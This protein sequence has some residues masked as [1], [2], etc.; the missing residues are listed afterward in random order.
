MN[1]IGKKQIIEVI[2][3]NQH[4]PYDEVKRQAEEAGLSPEQFEESWKTAKLDPSVDNDARVDEIITE[5]K[6][7]GKESKTHAQWKEYLK[8]KGYYDDEV[9]LAYVLT[10]TKIKFNPL[11]TWC[12]AI[13]AVILTAWISICLIAGI[14]RISEI[15]IH[16]FIL[17]LVAI[18]A[19]LFF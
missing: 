18:L 16:M 6:T 15:L 8:N 11:S 7:A 4:L 13:I 19:Y 5:M 17:L 2:K 1:K 9:D 14:Y 12:F 3:A 10:D